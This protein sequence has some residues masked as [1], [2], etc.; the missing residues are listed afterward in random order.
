MHILGTTFE[1]HST[2]GCGI[3]WVSNVC[4][5]SLVRPG[6]R[7]AQPVDAQASESLLKTKFFYYFYSSFTVMFY[8]RV[9]LRTFDLRFLIMINDIKLFH[10]NYFIII[11]YYN[12]YFNFNF[13]YCTNFN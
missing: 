5:L 1:S 11:L 6:S 3:A 4:V 10:F 2:D 8:A 7:M 12:N 9:I 13:N